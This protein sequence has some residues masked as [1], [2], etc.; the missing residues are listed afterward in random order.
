MPNRAA[1]QEEG[2]L[3]R[4]HRSP[5]SFAAYEAD[6]AGRDKRGG[7]M[8]R[9]KA[10]CLYTLREGGFIRNNHAPVRGVLRSAAKRVAV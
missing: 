7:K 8:S 1:E 4:E 6:R 9:T 5:G 10:Y 3:V 2:Y